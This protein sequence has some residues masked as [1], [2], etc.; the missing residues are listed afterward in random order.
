MH[1]MGKRG[2]F[3]KR[4]NGDPERARTSII[5]EDVLSSVRRTGQVLIQWAVRFGYEHGRVARHHGEPGVTHYWIKRERDEKLQSSMRYVLGTRT[6]SCV[7]L[8]RC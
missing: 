4:G 7:S 8:A 5:R 1:V 6:A 2:A 3:G